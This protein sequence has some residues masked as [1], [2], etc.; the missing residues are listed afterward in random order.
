MVEI[1]LPL[2]QKILSWQHTGFNVHSKVRATSKREAARFA[3]SI[4]GTA[5]RRTGTPDGG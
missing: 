3:I 4:R 5:H 1:G 2:V